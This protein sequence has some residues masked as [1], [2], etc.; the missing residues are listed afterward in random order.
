MQIDNWRALPPDS[1]GLLIENELRK[2]GGAAVR[3]IERVR[4]RTHGLT[5]PLTVPVLAGQTLMTLTVGERIVWIMWIWA[6][7]LLRSLIRRRTN[8]RRP[9]RVALT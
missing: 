2:R 8:A 7:V 1:V 9:T 6:V 5:L 3:V 4:P